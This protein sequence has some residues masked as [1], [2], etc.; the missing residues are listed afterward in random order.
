LCWG[1]NN[2]KKGYPPR[3]NIV[4]DEKGDFVTDCHSILARWRNHFS[5]LFNV[6]GVNDV[7]QTEIHTAEP[8]VP[9]PNAN[10]LEMAIESPRRHKS[11]GIA[12]IPAELIKRGVEL[13]P[14]RTINLL[15]P[16]GIKR[17]CLRSGRIRSFLPIYK[18]GDT[19]DYGYYRGI[20]L[21]PTKYRTLS[22]ILLSRL[23][24]YAEVIIG[25]HQCGF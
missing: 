9:K 22:N 16:S 1:I 18:K 14:L 15:I 2:F 11:P 3:T 4:K 10:E 23:T 13:F 19:K 25:D 21:L 7:R 20:S 5:Q 12:Q 8:L 6:H 17:N 24:I